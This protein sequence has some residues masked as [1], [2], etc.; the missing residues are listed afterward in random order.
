MTPEYFDAVDPESHGDVYAAREETVFHF[1][2]AAD[3]DE[4]EQLLLRVTG[5]DDPPD[6]GGTA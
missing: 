2:A 5:P 6:D 3:A 1:E 4:N